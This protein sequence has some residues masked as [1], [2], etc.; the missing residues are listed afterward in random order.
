MLLSQATI[1][2]EKAGAGDVSEADAIFFES[3]INTA[4]FFISSILPQV[5]GKLDAIEKN[6]DVVLRIDDRYFID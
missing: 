1:A 2:Q 5:A 4:K 6:D 3:K